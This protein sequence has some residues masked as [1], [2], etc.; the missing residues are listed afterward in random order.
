LPRGVFDAPRSAMRTIVSRD[1]MAGPS[2]STASERRMDAPDPGAKA[3]AIRLDVY[4]RGQGTP[5]R[6]VVMCACALLVASGA[7]WLYLLPATGSGWYTPVMV[8][9]GALVALALALGLIVVM[10]R[11]LVRGKSDRDLLR[12]GAMTGA[13]VLASVAAWGINE[14]IL[15]GIDAMAR[16][17]IQVVFPFNWGFLISVMA[18]VYGLWASF[19]ILVNHPQ[20]AEFLIETETEMRK[21]AWPTRREYL[22]ASV[23]VIIIIAI[24]SCYISFVDLVLNKLLG[25]LKIGY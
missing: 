13:V 4:K 6:V 2:S 23:V 11:T 12:W 15:V 5:I 17:L 22:G 9:G 21:V 24:V 3:P 20:R 1:D 14:K 25:W 7:H 10:Y 19:M 8:T 16:P 18:F